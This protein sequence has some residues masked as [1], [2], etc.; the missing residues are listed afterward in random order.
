MAQGY[1]NYGDSSYST[2]PTEDNKY[3][4]QTGPLEGI[5]VSSVEFCKFK[6][7]DR[8]DSARDNRTGTQGP[9]GPQ[10]PQGIQGLPG[11][12]GTQGPQGI[13][14]L[15]GATGT[16]GPSGITQ[17]N[18]ANTYNVTTDIIITFDG[19]TALGQGI[20]TC[21]VGDFAIS[22][23]YILDVQRTGGYELYILA[24]SFDGDNAWKV[25][26]NS[27]IIDGSLL[28]GVVTAKCFDNP[29]LR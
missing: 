11:A 23:G 7:D 9:P 2:Y 14:G 13:Q 16:Q 15:P 3:E 20:A 12:T 1:D 19:S 6:F 28:E 5:F 25:R 17:L 4:C 18:N 29:P 10:G 21:D 27:D 8:K 26:F 24:N 22:G